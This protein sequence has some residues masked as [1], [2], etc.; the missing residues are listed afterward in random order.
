[1]ADDDKELFE[2]ALTTEPENEAQPEPEAQEHPD[3]LPRDEHGRFAPKQKAAEQPEAQAQPDA[4]PPEVKEQR[5]SEG[6]PPWRL[7]EEADARRAA[8]ERARQYERDMADLRRQIAQQQQ[9][10]QSEKIPDI[11]EDANGFVDHNVRTAIDPVKSEIS[12][13]R[14]FYS[15]QNAVREFGA[16]K[17]KAAYDAI[18]QAL[19]SHDPE[20]HAVLQ[21]ARESMDPFGDI[22]RWHQKTTVFNQI[23]ADPN[24]WFEKQLE[25]RL[26]DPAHQAKL[27]E[28]IRGNVQPAQ[29]PV[30]QLPPS[31]NKQTAAAVSDDDGDDNSD[32]GLL[33]SA[34]RR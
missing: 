29:R 28:R 25:D 21:R 8:E 4:T 3:N 33:K 10:K 34:L 9:N 30:T 5:Q 23:G 15:Q 22:V 12:R 27:I 24:A 18:D 13:L 26:K 17:V 19:M 6:I 16:E 2:S 32:A 31:L 7:K 14:E 1:M 11:F 20:A